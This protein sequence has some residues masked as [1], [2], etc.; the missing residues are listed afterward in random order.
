M[1][2]TLGTKRLPSIFYFSNYWTQNIILILYTMNQ[3]SFSYY[4]VVIMY[5]TFHTTPSLLYSERTWACLFCCA[6]LPMR[7]KELTF[8]LSF[9][10][11]LKGKARY[12]VGRLGAHFSGFNLN[13]TR[14]HVLSILDDK[15]SSIYFLKLDLKF[16]S[17]YVISSRKSR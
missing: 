8:W 13:F 14:T 10:V 3:T 2:N 6:M 16:L 12:Q 15:K 1:E 7:V 5:T 4:L 17:K 11:D 9:M